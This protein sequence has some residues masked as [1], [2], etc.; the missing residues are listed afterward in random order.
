[1]NREQ[2]MMRQLQEEQAKEKKQIDISEKQ[3]E[4]E[5]IM[6]RKERDE[7][8][9]REYKQHYQHIYEDQLNKAI[10]FSSVIAKEMQKENQID[11]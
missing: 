7:K 9:E 6:Q 10:R 11:N 5:L 3:R 4:M 1:M 8:R 2:Q